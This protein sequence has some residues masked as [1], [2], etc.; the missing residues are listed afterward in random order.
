MFR[1]KSKGREFDNVFVTITRQPSGA[2]MMVDVDGPPEGEAER[3][4]RISEPFPFDASSSSAPGWASPRP[5][6]C[7]PIPAAPSGSSAWT[8]SSPTGRASAISWA[9]R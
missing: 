3:A 7:W 4:V 1:H 8:G 5:R 6:A 2:V 9:A